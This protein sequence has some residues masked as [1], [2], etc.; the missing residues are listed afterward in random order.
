MSASGGKKACSERVTPFFSSPNSNGTSNIVVP[1]E[2]HRDAWVGVNV[3]PPNSFPNCFPATVTKIPL[4][5]C[6]PRSLEKSSQTKDIGSS[7]F[8]LWKR[9][10]RTTTGHGFDRMVDSE[11]P[12]YMR[13]FWVTVI[14][15]LLSG[16][17]TSIVI[18]SYEEL[19]VRELRRE[20]IV[21]YNKTMLLPDI[22]ICDTS[23]FNRTILEGKFYSCVL[24]FLLVNV[25]LLFLFLEM[26]INNTMASYL[27]LALSH[28]LASRAIV[29]DTEKRKL[30]DTEFRRLMKNKTISDVFDR[31]TL[32]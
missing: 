24:Y 14:V 7:F 1:A 11:E 15:V 12:R 26:G 9:F 3:T 30:L 19:V 4:Q 16:L 23:L 27:T 6:L 29:E 17:L 28:L 22:H 13:T 21:R 5:H 25:H 10:A 32:R 18:I 2:I 31:A 20:F 8:S